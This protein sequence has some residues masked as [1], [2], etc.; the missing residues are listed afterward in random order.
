MVAIQ[1]KCTY[2]QYHKLTVWHITK[3]NLLNN[4]NATKISLEM[5][6]NEAEITDADEEQVGLLYSIGIKAIIDIYCTRGME[7]SG[8]AFMHLLY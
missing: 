2:N 6:L 8:S 3:G 5:F 1:F 4:V 7:L